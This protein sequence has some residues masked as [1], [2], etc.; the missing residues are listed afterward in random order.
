MSI[1]ISPRFDVRRTAGGGVDSVVSFF[2]GTAAWLSFTGS[3]SN[4]AGEGSGSAVLASF[5][6]SAS[7]KIGYELGTDHTKAGG[8][9]THDSLVYGLLQVLLGYY[10]AIA[11]ADP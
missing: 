7:Y 4:G 6:A 3:D 11:I 1:P 5:G 2:G 8:M 9:G 10:D